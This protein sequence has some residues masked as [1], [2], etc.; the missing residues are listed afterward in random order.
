MPNAVYTPLTA[1]RFGVSAPVREVFSVRPLGTVRRALVIANPGSR[2]GAGTALDRVLGDRT[3]SVELRVRRLAKGE[4]AALATREELGEAWDVVVVA[5]GD[6]TVAGVAAA[7]GEAGVPV[8]IAPVGTAN[9]LAMQLGLPTRLEDAVGL[10]AGP[11]AARPI[12]GMEIGGRLH[13]LCVGA[14]VSA[15]TVRDLRDTDKRRFG[16]ASYFWV[17]IGSAWSFEPTRC[18]IS[19]D[20]KRMRR[21]ILDVS[22]LNAGFRS[23]HPIPGMPDIRPDDGKLDVL[24]VWAPRL[25]EYLRHLGRALMFGRRVRPTVAWWTAER[26]V[27]IDCREPLPVHADGDSFGET[28]VTIRLVRNAVEIVVPRRDGPSSQR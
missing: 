3:A 15:K 8:L 7:A 11:A 5:G 2:D 22:V 9:M 14:G 6:G 12:D 13:F 28:P 17:G 27:A 26:D 23:D 16:V 19:I 25:S 1:G 18:T 21:R 24:V 4:D 10:L 20:G